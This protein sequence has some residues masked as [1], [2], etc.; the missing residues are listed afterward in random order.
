[1]RHQKINFAIHCLAALILLSAQAARAQQL[2]PP[3]SPSVSS[4]APAAAPT[5]PFPG[6]ALFNDQPPFLTGVVVDRADATY[7]EGDKLR[8]QFQGEIE[9][10]LYLLYHQADGSTILLFPNA[11]HPESKVAAKQ[12]VAI[13][14]VKDESREDFR[15]RVRPPLGREMLQ[16]VASKTPLTE[17]ESLAAQRGKAPLVAA[18]TLKSLADRLLADRTTWTEHRVAVT[19]LA[20]AAR[21]PERKPARVGLFIGIG[22]YKNPGNAATHEELRH[23]AEVMH[24]LMLKHGGLDPDRT[25]L[26][27]DE[28]ATKAHLQ[29]LIAEKLPSI[30]QPGD[31]VFIYFSGH[32][33][34]LDT[35]DPSE[36][37]GKD[38]S[39]GPYDLEG[40]RPGEPREVG[41][42]RWRATNITDDTLAAWLSRL[43]GRQIVLILDTCHSAGVIEGKNLATTFWQDEAAR[44]KDIN[45]LNTI[46]LASCAGDEQTLF[47]GTPNK[48]MYFTFCLSEIIE[49]AAGKEPLTVQAAFEYSRRHMRV[50]LQQSNAPREQEPVMSDRIL[51]PVVL[52]PQR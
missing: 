4:T 32:A 25:L 33:G 43:A 11:A 50:L 10:H 48:T 6:S 12:P 8:V 47:E 17:L 29:E 27:R 7:R 38:E 13:P 16:V 9:A 28:Q 49:R 40:T 3:S 1:M 46:V 21:P 14:P 36:P 41:A 26:V 19:T 35:N 24:D 52:V 15:F 22:K 31:I 45:Q 44:L 18:G 39:I 51:L 34:Q 42:A 30:T 20:A 5:N 2:A 37:D 23:S